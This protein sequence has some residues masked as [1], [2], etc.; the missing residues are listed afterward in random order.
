MKANQHDPNDALSMEQKALWSA[1][2]NAQVTGQK[3]NLFKNTSQGSVS[4]YCPSKHLKIEVGDTYESHTSSLP[5]KM[6]SSNADRIL[7]I[8]KSRIRRDI[9]RVLAQ[10]QV[11]L[12]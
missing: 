4:F 8:S 11:C 9:G 2:K 7:H 5:N 12:L 10:I 3:F 6:E 1:L